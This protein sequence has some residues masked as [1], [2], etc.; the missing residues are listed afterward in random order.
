MHD[1]TLDHDA[2]KLYRNTFKL[3]PCHGFRKDIIATVKS[4]SLWKEVLDNWG[5]IKGGKWIKQNPLNVKGMMNEYERRSNATNRN[6]SADVG[7]TGA[8]G[9]PV[10]RH[11]DLLPVREGTRVHPRTDGET[12]R[13]L[14]IS[15]RAKD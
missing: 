6:Q 4:L 14:S 10:R 8:A 9:L 12:L 13:E 7:E 2:V 11:R 15:L 3:T 5:Y 1:E